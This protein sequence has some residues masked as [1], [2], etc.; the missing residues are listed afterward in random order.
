MPLP[1]PTGHTCTHT[2]TRPD[3]TTTVTRTEYGTA[4]GVEATRTVVT[5]A[6]DGRITCTAFELRDGAW[7]AV[8]PG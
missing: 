3:G 6:A 2:V 8:P 7:V 1:P 5:T 4:G